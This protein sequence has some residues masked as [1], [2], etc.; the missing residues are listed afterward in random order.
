M[1]FRYHKTDFYIVLLVTF[2]SSFTPDTSSYDAYGLKIA[3]NDVLFVQSNPSQRFFRIFPPSNSWSYCT[4]NYEDMNQYI[5]AVAVARQTTLNDTIRFVFTGVK[6]TDVPFMG[7]LTYVNTSVVD[8][9][10]TT[11]TIEDFVFSCDGWNNSN[12]KIHTIDQFLYDTDVQNDNH[13]D[14]FVVAVE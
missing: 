9:T 10:S 8:N 4:I 1:R 14:F 11:M 6:T 3:A 2:V 13:L 7:S 12:Y 5:Y